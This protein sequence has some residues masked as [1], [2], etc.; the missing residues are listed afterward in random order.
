MYILKDSTVYLGKNLFGVASKATAPEIDMETINIKTLGSIGEYNLNGGVKAMT[1]SLTITG[2]DKEVFSKVANPY[3][4]I[5]LMILGS[6]KKFENENLVDELP[7]KLSIRGSSQKFSL[8][9]ELEAQSNIE[10][11]ID[12]NVSAARL[13]IN[14]KEIYNIDVINNIWIVNGVD[15][16]AK[17]RKNLGLS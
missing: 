15:L 9:G 4:E 8:L 16:L 5:N 17:M 12:F 10:Q 7:A 13:T 3:A 11:N 14:K 2:F 1:S 6:I